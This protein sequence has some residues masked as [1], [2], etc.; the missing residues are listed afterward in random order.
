MQPLSSFNQH[1]GIEKTVNKLSRL[2]G[3]NLKYGATSGTNT[4]R[5]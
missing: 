4:N 2:E 1:I 5:Y 3:I